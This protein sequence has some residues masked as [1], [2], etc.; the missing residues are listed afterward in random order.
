M[1]VY[2]GQVYECAE[3]PELPWNEGIDLLLTLDGEPG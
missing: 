2:R 1:A 3:L